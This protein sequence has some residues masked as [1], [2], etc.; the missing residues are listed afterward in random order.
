ME[1]KKILFSKNY[2]SKDGEDKISW[3]NGGVC[4]INYSNNEILSINLYLNLLPFNPQVKIY[5]KDF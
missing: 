2:K 5:L 1:H 3:S 4:F